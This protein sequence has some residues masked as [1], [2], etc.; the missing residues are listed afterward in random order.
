MPSDNEQRDVD[1][2]RLSRVSYSYA[3]KKVMRARG[4]A[5]EHKCASCGWQASQWAYIV[6]DEHEQHGERTS[7]GRKGVPSTYA[8]KWSPN[9]WAYEPLCVPCHNSQKDGSE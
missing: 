5:C 3:H 7:A 9:V 8:V 2:T 4:R 1:T 6:G